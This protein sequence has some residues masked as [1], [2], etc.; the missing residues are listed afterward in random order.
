MK[1][2]FKLILL[3]TLILV[4]GCG[5]TDY[6]TQISDEL[7][8]LYCQA[9]AQKDAL[10]IIEKN[11]QKEFPLFPKYLKYSDA[12]YAKYLSEFDALNT[13]IENTVAT[14]L[15][16]NENKTGIISNAKRYAISDPIC[17]PITVNERNSSQILKDNIAL[18]KWNNTSDYRSSFSEW[19]YK[20][21]DNDTKPHTDDVFFSEEQAFFV[22]DLIFPKQKRIATLNTQL[23]SSKLQ[24]KQAIK[25]SEDYLKRLKD[26]Y[27]TNITKFNNRIKNYRKRISQ[28]YNSINNNNKKINT[29][30]RKYKAVI[31][32]KRRV[33]SKIKKIEDAVN[34]SPRIT[35]P[36]TKSMLQANPEYKK[37]KSDAIR[38]DREKVAYGKQMST[39]KIQNNSSRS[40]ISNL[41]KSITNNY[42]EIT[43]TKN[44]YNAELK[45]HIKK[46]NNEAQFLTQQIKNIFAEIQK[47][48]SNNDIIQIT[49]SNSGSPVTLTS[50]KNLENPFPFSLYDISFDNN[51]IP[52]AL[53]SDT[54]KL[55]LYKY[56]ESKNKWNKISLDYTLPLDSNASIIK[57]N[58]IIEGNAIYCLINIASVQKNDVKFMKLEKTSSSKYILSK[59]GIIDFST[60]FNGKFE[61]SR[62]K[63]AVDIQM[64][65][66]EFIFSFIEGTNPTTSS[67]TYTA[68]R[69]YFMYTYSSKS[70][71]NLNSQHVI[72]FTLS[73]LE[74]FPTSTTSLHHLNQKNT[75]WW[76][77]LPS[78]E[79]AKTSNLLVSSDMGKHWYST[80]Q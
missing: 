47:L 34:R 29:I 70:G 66:D 7:Q 77:E 1:Y 64:A 13:Q 5:F 57:P 48:K 65:K 38:L 3:G 68:F 15:K 24:Q 35:R 27:T 56:Q 40:V 71:A 55:V 32:K 50:G 42:K 37:L 73:N 26:N 10:E 45:S 76:I 46:S 12:I 6:E 67:Q 44:R 11:Y 23:E 36:F 60:N 52:Y 25:N 49:A 22:T 28:Y 17:E 31:S 62:I 78:S 33:V 59:E 20:A 41:K 79:S 39:I 30:N 16:N 43:K 53:V 4:S 69:N 80:N 74:K 19:L 51:N 58:L 18:A 54:K 63:L 21:A 2:F 61:T 9:N 14:K 75:N 8:L 72:N